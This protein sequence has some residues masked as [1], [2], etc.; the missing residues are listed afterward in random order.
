[1]ATQLS[2][3]KIPALARL[4]RRIV[5]GLLA[6][7]LGGAVQLTPIML[8][9]L[10]P[11]T[12]EADMRGRMLVSIVLAFIGWTL[13]ITGAVFIVLGCIDHFRDRSPSNPR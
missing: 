8:I 1:M 7:V 3:P 10:N 9:A 2:T 11:P 4:P 6:V 13:F 12:T 5:I